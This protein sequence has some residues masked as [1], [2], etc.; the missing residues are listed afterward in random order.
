MLPSH[1]TLA[2]GLSLLRHHA[3]GFAW[4]SKLRG[5][6]VVSPH[7]GCKVPRPDSHCATLGK[8]IAVSHGWI[9]GDL[10]RHD[11][12]RTRVYLGKQP[13]GWNSPPPPL[14]LFSL[15]PL[16]M[17]QPAHLHTAALK[18]LPPLWVSAPASAA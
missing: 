8:V 10:F 7:G 9:R 2:Q 3:C 16:H 11:S 4:L 1:Q 5:T 18:C 12:P 15:V 6:L 13:A 17:T 14:P